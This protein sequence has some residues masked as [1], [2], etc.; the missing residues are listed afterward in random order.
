MKKGFLFV[1]MASVIGTAFGLDKA[2]IPKIQPKNTNEQNCLKVYEVDREEF[3]IGNRL[4]TT[5]EYM[6]ENTSSKILEGEFEFPLEENEKVTGYDLDIDG[7]YRHAVAIEKEKARQVFEDVVRR[8]VDP[9]LVEMTAGNNFKTRVYPINA[10]GV[11]HLKITIDREIEDKNASGQV[12]TQTVGK[13]SYFY[14]YQDL[15]DLGLEKPV[16]NKAIDIVQ[17]LFDVSSSAKNRDIK[18]EIAFLEMYCSQ[19]NPSKILIIP[20]ADTAKA[21]Y[22]ASDFGKAK[23]FLENYSKMN[24][25]DG[26]TSFKFDEKIMMGDQ[27]LLFSDGIENWQKDSGRT[28]SFAGKVVNS[29]CS[30]EYADYGNLKKIAAENGG[31]FLNLRKMDVAQAIDRL[32]NPSPRILEIKS[33][34]EKLTDLYPLAGEEVGTGVSIAGIVSKKSGKVSLSIG[35]SKENAKVY[36]YDV[37]I[38]E[39]CGGIESEKTASFWAEK[40]IDALSANYQKNKNEI[41]ELAKEF[42]IVTQDT[43]LVVLEN[44]SDYVRYGIT[45]PAELRKEYDRLVSNQF[46]PAVKTEKTGVP[47]YVY[48]NFEI[49]K[50][51]WNTKPG[52][53]KKPDEKKPR[54]PSVYVRND[55][56]AVENEVEIFEDSM[57]M[58]SMESSPVLRDNESRMAVAS[59]IAEKDRIE[60]FEPYAGG[61]QA[62]VVLKPWSSGEEYLEVLAKTEDKKMYGKYLELKAE[63]HSSPAF[64]IECADYFMEQDQKSCAMR[65][66]SNLAE[67]NLENSD[68]LRALGNKL[69]EWKEY[70]LA[71]QILKDL[72]QKFP[73]IPL[74][75]RDLALAYQGDGKMQ[76]AIETLWSVVNSEVDGRYMEIQN[77]CLNDMNSIIEEEMHQKHVVDF[78]GIDRKLVYN[79][80]VDLRIVLTWNTDNCDVDL[81]VTDPDGEKCYYGNKLTNNGGRISRDFTQGYGPEEFCIKNAPKGKYKIQAHYYGNHQ[82]K[83]LQPVVVQAEVYTNFGRP[84]QEKQVLTLQLNDVKQEFLIGEVEVK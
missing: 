9:G 81:W 28:K 41:I 34:G 57:M 43:S 75:K 42:T 80:W 77:I 46:A 72:S 48:R 36:E 79:M 53:F 47:D 18:K 20:F 74:L 16:N 50:K 35:Y 64:Y 51:W 52:E 70:D 14:I 25:F 82:Q 8:G 56:A 65:I 1:L 66:L 4:C 30:S 22:L 67:I 19:F 17:I 7:T 6:I 84:D 58:E 37:S 68:V 61:T 54:R 11:R 32:I 5:I 2:R 12:Y 3:Q 15:G 10:K 55:S 26:A 45:P 60:E 59:P 71:I 76:E 63:F 24:G 49:Y 29:I 73:E 44:V 27:I 69:Y 40:K 23:E 21:P 38:V 62:S 78:S 13:K 83:Q 39:G 31:V 33:D